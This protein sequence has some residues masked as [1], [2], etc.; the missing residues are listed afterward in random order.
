MLYFLEATG[1]IVRVVPERIYQGSSEGNKIMLIAPF[2]NTVMAEVVFKLPDGQLTLPYKLNY[3]GSM[4]ES[5]EKAICKMHA[6]QT[7]LPITV[8]QHYGG[9]EVQFYFTSSKN[10]KIASAVTSF[11]VER[12]LLPTLPDSPTEDVYQQLKESLATIQSD[13]AN[14]FYSAR[15]IYAWNSSYTYNAN[16][17]TFY[18]CGKYGAFIQSLQAENKNI[19]IVDGI[20]DSA[21]KV[22]ISFDTIADSFFEELKSIALEARAELQQ[23][24]NIL[25]DLKTLNNSILICVDKLPEH[26][27]KNKI[28]AIL[29]KDSS[30][31]FSLYVWV[32][33]WLCLGEKGIES[34]TQVPEGA[35]LYLPQSLTLEQQLQARKNIGAQSAGD[36]LVE[37]QLREHLK[38]YPTTATVDSHLEKQAEQLQNT[39]NSKM[40]ELKTA[41]DG[42]MLMQQQDIVVEVDSKLLE[43]NRQLQEKINILT[44]EIENLQNNDDKNSNAPSTLTGSAGT[45][46][47]P[48]YLEDGKIKACTNIRAEGDSLQFITDSHCSADCKNRNIFIGSKLSTLGVQRESTI[49]GSRLLCAGEKLV[50]IGTGQVDGDNL[51]SIGVESLVNGSYSVAV[52]PLATA[53]GE[54]SCA[55]GPCAVSTEDFATVIGSDENKNVYYYGSLQSKSD[56]RDKADIEELDNKKSLQFINALRTVTYVN[57]DRRKYRDKSKKITDNSVGEYDKVAHAKGEKKGHR[58]QIGV[59]A[60]DVEF[61]MQKIYKKEIA[62]LVNDSLYKDALLATK[63]QLESQKF[64]NYIAFIPLLIS[65]M[66]EQQKQIKALKKALNSIKKESI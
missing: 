15:A 66:Q 55:I 19:P 26:G 14:A 34:L 4:Q 54:M 48:I 12:G 57:N 56:M 10:E 35:V 11:I 7:I 36:Y 13:L 1:S 65:A 39:L 22:L 2:A 27:E 51:V 5:A 38:E 53:Q 32:D 42:Q 24:Q 30:Q 8:T 9:V 44:E 46:S 45:V 50:A 18:P 62:N 3:I 60:Q 28:Y 31:L 64:V 40:I 43:V 61:N 52:G 58:R 17:I 63:N 59:L 21:W 25:A 23:V 33:K 20:V 47:H 29:S 49:L 37:E 6:W 41:I 16:E